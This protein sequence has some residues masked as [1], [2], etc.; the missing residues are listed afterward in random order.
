MNYDSA[1]ENSEWALRV[2]S[3]MD[4]PGSRSDVDSNLFK[5]EWVSV[6]RYL[7]TDNLCLLFVDGRFV[8][9]V[10]AKMCGLPFSTRP[11]LV[12]MVTTEPLEKLLKKESGELLEAVFL[13]EVDLRYPLG[14]AFTGDDGTSS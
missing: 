12:P 8:R 13:P 11:G 10:D 5:G 14:R 9:R 6:E 1:L 2:I 4:I 7:G 3:V